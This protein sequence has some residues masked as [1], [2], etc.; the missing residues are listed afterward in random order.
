M[1]Y[2]LRKATNLTIEVFSVSGALVR[3]LEEGLRAAGPYALE[4]D[5]RDEMGR[6]VA[7]GV[8]LARIAAGGE[9]RTGRVVITR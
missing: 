2:G 3:R 8:Y 6:A 5:G 4:W 1:T 9:R 7:S